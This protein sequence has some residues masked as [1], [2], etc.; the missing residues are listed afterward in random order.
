MNTNLTLMES[1]TKNRKTDIVKCIQKIPGPPLV[2]H[3][4]GSGIIMYNLLEQ[5]DRHRRLKSS[6]F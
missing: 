6:I 3:C 2:Q 1:L 5:D 4:L